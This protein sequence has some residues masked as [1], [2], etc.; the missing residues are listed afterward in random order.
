MVRLKRAWDGG[1]GAPIDC[2]FPFHYGSIETCCLSQRSRWRNGFPFHIGSI[3][4]KFSLPIIR[5]I[6]YF[7]NHFYLYFPFPSS[8]SIFSRILYLQSTMLLL[9]PGFWLRASVPCS[10]FHSTMVRLR[11]GFA[12]GLLKVKTISIPLWFDWDVG[13]ERPENEPFKI[14]IPQWFDWDWWGIGLGIVVGLAFPFQNGSIETNK[15]YQSLGKVGAISIPLWFDW[16]SGQK[17]F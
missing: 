12:L 9:N 1:D 2:P 7:R 11:P 10:N 13:L 14:S 16:D 5:N 15:F 3:E 17:T 8:F 4:T 6:K